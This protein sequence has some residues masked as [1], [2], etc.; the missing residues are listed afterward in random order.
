MQKWPNTK[1]LMSVITG[2]GG[3]QK[4]KTVL[5]V[6]ENI[7]NL[8]WPLTAHIIVNIGYGDMKMSK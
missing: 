7:D 2:R 5:F 4:V 6:R 1:I 8:G 3:G